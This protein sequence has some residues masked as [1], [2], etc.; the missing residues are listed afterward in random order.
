MEARI[1]RTLSEMIG[2]SVVV[3]PTIPVDPAGDYHYQDSAKP[4]EAE[5][6]GSLY[7]SVTRS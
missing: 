5:P 4:C 1:G 6:Q 2:K 7:C 3:L